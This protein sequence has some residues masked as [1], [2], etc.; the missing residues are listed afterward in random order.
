MIYTVL[1]ALVEDLNRH[2]QRSI[3]EARTLAALS[4]L[5]DLDGNPATG[6]ENRIVCTLTG[7]EQDKHNLNR[8][9]RAGAKVNPPIC[10]NLR[11]L[12]SA[13]FPGN[14]PEALKFL[15][16]LVG[17]FQNKQVFT[18]NNT[19][20]FPAGID[21][22]TVEIENQ[23]QR[24][25]NELW[26]AIGAKL[27]PSLCIRIRTVPIQHDRVL[28]EISEVRGVGVTTGLSPTPQD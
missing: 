7:L 27:V 24:E 26:G 12:L 8:P 9:P 10:L 16:L 15:D 23:E 17:Y 1:T 14:Y 5:V 28:E 13:N 2:L 22:L 18:P 6:I 19:P 3:S 25:L 4:G 11:L 20:D 21:K